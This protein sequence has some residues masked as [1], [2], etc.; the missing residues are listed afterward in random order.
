MGSGSFSGK[1]VVFQETRARNTPLPLISKM[2]WFFDQGKGSSISSVDELNTFFYMQSG[3]ELPKAPEVKK[4]EP[5]TPTVLVVD[6]SVH[7]HFGGVQ[8]VFA[9]G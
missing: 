1:E 5:K 3:A 2:S 6:Q 9:Q 4:E 7:N 8:Q